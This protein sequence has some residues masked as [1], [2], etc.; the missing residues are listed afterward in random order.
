M[1]EKDLISVIIPIYNV[2]DFLAQCVDSVL[3][4]SYKNIEVILVDDG[5]PDNCGKI[6]DEYKNKDVRVKVIHKKNGGL[7]DARN[8]GIENS[9]GEYLC[10]IDSDDIIHKDF[11]KCQYENIISTN[12]DISVCLFSRFFEE[13]SIDHVQT[14]NVD[15]Q[16]L[17]NNQLILKIFEKNNIHYISACTKLYKKSLFDN[18]RFEVGRL[19]EDEFIVFHIFSHCQKAIFVNAPLYFYR[20]RPGSITMTKTYK[21]KNLDGFYS[22]QAC[23]NFFVGTQYEHLALNR[24]INSIAYIYCA[25]KTR[26]ADKK[27]LKFLLNQYKLY[28][29]LNNA[30]LL[31]QRLFYMFPNLIVKLKRLK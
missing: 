22:I 29:K 24:L 14:D 8:A 4:Q 27:I 10:F 16:E 13:Q 3:N 26:K 31:K 21:E 15:V 19:H 30:K 18:L 2:Q 6:C 9:S 25:A 12:S 23:Y 7:S 5:S 11:I 1:E 20:E 17:D 28:Y